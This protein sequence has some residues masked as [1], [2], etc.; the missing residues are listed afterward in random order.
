MKKN[1]LTMIVLLTTSIVFA[2]ST[3]RRTAP[4]KEETKVVA[5][6]SFEREFKNIIRVNP[7]AT[8]QALL[9]GGFEIDIQYSEYFTPKVAMPV[10]VSIFGAG[11]RIGFA[12][13]TGIEAVPIPDRQKSGLFLNA[14]AGPVVSG[15]TGII[16]N[17]KIQILAISL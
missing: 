11:D 16:I 15:S 1:L 13:L 5:V 10:E 4:Q 14:L 3:V 12:V 2:Q 9:N 6:E 17:P 7:L 8:I